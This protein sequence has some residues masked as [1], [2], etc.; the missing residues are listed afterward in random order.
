MYKRLFLIV[1]ALTLV[2]C[3][4]DGNPEA[5]VGGSSAA[6]GGSGDAGACARPEYGCPCSAEEEP[7]ECYFEPVVS[8]GEMECTVGTR[9]CESGSWGSCVPARTYTRT[10]TEEE[11]ALVDGPSACN[12]CN[13]DCRL[14][15]DYPVSRDLTA[16]NSSDVAMTQVAGLILG[17]EAGGAG[18]LP[19]RDG[20]GVPDVAD[21]YPGDASRPVSR[22][23]STTP[24]STAARR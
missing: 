17:E 11:A 21:G 22:V 14:Y 2:S 20:D 19:D 18:M 6:I 7:V 24:S 9:S 13:P 3:S 12:A 10:M 1:A 4:Q 16:S 5:P 23:A 15:R 8:G